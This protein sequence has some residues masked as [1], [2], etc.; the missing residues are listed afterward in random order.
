M[1]FDTGA[2]L[3]SGT[4][5]VGFPG[6]DGMTVLA[7]ATVFADFVVDAAGDALALLAVFVFLFAALDIVCRE[8]P[9]PMSESPQLRI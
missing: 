7:A 2:S 3:R 4:G 6:F 8:K 5:C 1:G 9:N